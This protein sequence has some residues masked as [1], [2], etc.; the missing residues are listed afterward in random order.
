MTNP[1]VARLLV[2]F[3][4]Q[5]RLERKMDGLFGRYSRLAEGG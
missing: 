1:H 4:A 5:I 3:S 2:S